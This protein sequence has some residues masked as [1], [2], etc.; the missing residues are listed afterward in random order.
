MIQ[1]LQT[2]TNA[3]RKMEICSFYN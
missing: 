1:C 3:K 2:K